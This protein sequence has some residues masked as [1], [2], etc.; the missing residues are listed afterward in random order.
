YRPVLHTF[1]QSHETESATAYLPLL[2][3][4]DARVRQGVAALLLD[5]RDRLRADVNRRTSWRERDL[6]TSRALAALE[7]AS[8]RLEAALGGANPTDARRVLLAISDVAN[9]DRSLEELLSIP[10]ARE[11]RSGEDAL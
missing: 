4:P 8:G 7:A 2:D 10:A 6:A 5:E 9:K 11:D 3:H 1:R